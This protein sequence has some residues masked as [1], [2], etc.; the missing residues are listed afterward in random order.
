MD[1]SQNK[2]GT[3]RI[4]PLIFSMALPAMV[5]MLINALYN[6]VDSIFV[7]RY[8]A[9]ALTAVSL[10]FPLQQL[11]IAI[12]VGTAVGVNSLI[13]RRLGAGM[14]KEADSAGEHGLALSVLGG[15]AF[16]LI[17]FFLS[18]PFLAAFTDKSSV[19]EQAVSYS[20]IAVGLSIFV[21]IS[22][23]CEKVQQSTG[24]MIIPMCQGLAGAI[25]NIILD[26]L[27][28]FGIGPFPEWGVRGAAIATVIGQVFGMVIG[29]WGVFSHQKLLHLNMRSFRLRGEIVLDIYRVGLPGIIMQSV[30]SVMTAGLNLIL[31]S[32]SEVAVSV[33]GI[34]FKLQT[35]VFM[36]VFGLNQG[37]LP[38]MGF[39][40]GA[41]NRA[42]LMSAYKVT[43]TSAFCIML[44]GLV[45]F[46][47]LPRQMLLLFADAKDAAASAALLE[48]GIPALRTISWSFL[49]AAF[50]IIN[51]TLFQAI[52]RGMASLIVSVC[53]QLVV[54]LPV[55]WLLGQLHGLAAIWYAFPIAEIVAFAISYVL[56]YR[57]YR[58]DLCRLDTPKEG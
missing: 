39:N 44:I 19:L 51:S 35:F 33:L 49:G 12:A 10:V 48:T 6:I 36:P 9:D 53:R 17:G 47:L 5:S 46:Q 57:I 15:L 52:G 7:A 4:A 43:L 40:Y 28:I 23:M 34:Y 42:R 31:I 37:A 20:H 1:S 32:F 18:R 50:G 45:L 14:Q 27:M 29:L 13:A 54:I 41:R 26:P 55:A 8:S 38:V 21:M 3:H 56:L 30:V 24:N 25:V 11:V 16:I 22:V 2:M 58:I